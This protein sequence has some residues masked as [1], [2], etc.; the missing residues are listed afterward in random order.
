MTIARKLWLGFGILIL[1]FLLTALAVGTSVRSVQEALEEIVEVEEPT[2][3]AAYEM[4][5]NTVEI[6]RGVLNYLETGDPEARGQTKADRAGFEEVMGIYDELID[7]QTGAEQGERIQANYDEYVALGENLMDERND[8]DEIFVAVGDEFD[9][10]GG[11]VAEG[12]TVAE[13][14]PGA[15]VDELEAL[16]EVESG[17]FRANSSLV[18]YLRAPEAEYRE[19]FLTEVDEVR[20]RITRYRELDL[21]AEEESRARDLEERFEETASRAEEGLISRASILRDTEEFTRLQ[22]TLDDILDDEIQP[23]TRR[24]LEEAEETASSEISDVYWSLLGLIAVGL[25]VG[26]GAASLIARGILRSVRSLKEGAGRIGGGDLDH[27]IEPGS[28][29]ELAEVAVAFNF[30][31]ARRQEEERELESL[32]R[33]NKLI[34]DSAGEG[35]YGLD[36]EGKTTFV[37]PAAL[38]TLGYEAEELVGQPVHALT[39]HTRPDGTPYPPK[40]CPIYG[41]LGDGTVHRVSDEVFWRK[42]GTS[43]PVEYV[44]TPIFENGEAVG[45]VVTFSDITARRENEKALQESEEQYR[46]LVETV[47]EGIAF[48]DGDDNITYCNPAYAEIFGLA[49]GDL[50]GRKLTGFFDE[51]GMRISREQKARRRNNEHSEYELPIIAADG[52]RRIL[53][54]SG[55]PILGADGSFQG[56]VQAIVDVTERKKAERALK[57]SELR[58]RT[59]VA[60]APVVLFALDH[61]GVFT[62]SEGKGLEQLGI[63]RNELVGL[64]VFDVYADHPRVVE[65]ARRSL[66]GEELNITLELGD[67]VYESYYS[68]I[69]EENGTVSGIIG[70]SI[71]VTERVRPEKETQRFYELMER[72]VERRTAQLAES[73]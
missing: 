1:L 10:L 14:E 49:A 71:D 35:I 45:A 9:A 65:G 50:V 37:N 23:W 4:E 46:R 3:E 73:E 68:P 21:T 58:L 15:D 6:G 42:D 22:E 32:S 72:R 34:L 62:L 70:V 33:Q 30:M 13:N 40:E 63:E 54:S 29:D 17:I 19:E 20:E 43:F 11:L 39:H 47:Q 16:A 44:S 52:G 56:S 38:S 24:Q 53:S 48:I 60:N 28:R 69:R 12:L 36:G 55:S 64:S 25:V 7:T 59:V 2:E 66:D 18:A 61:R 51:E 31:A 67:L 8:V 57:E 41:A 27:R 5:I 26:V